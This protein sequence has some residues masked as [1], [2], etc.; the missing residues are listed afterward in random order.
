MNDQT[1][2]LLSWKGEQQGMYSS[3]EIKR[4]W[5]SE[6]ISGLYNVVT[7]SG[8][9][10]VQEFVSFEQEQSGKENLHQQQLAQAQ[11]EVEKQRFERDRL[12]AEKNQRLEIERKKAEQEKVEQAQLNEQ[13]SGKT[14]YLYLDGKKKGPYSK[15]NLQIMHQGGRIDES[16]QVWTQDLGEWVELKGFKEIVGSSNVLGPLPQPDQFAQSLSQQYPPQYGHAPSAYPPPSR[17]NQS[18]DG[19]A[20]SPILPQKPKTPEGLIAW[21]WTLMFIPSIIGALLIAT[22]NPAG[23][24]IGTLIAIGGALGC[25]IISIVL[26]CSPSMAGRVNG[27]IVL[28]L[29]IL[30]VIFQIA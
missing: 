28:A 21:V 3:T 2:A 6:E 29:I 8:N 20:Q 12:Q 13:M 18:G 30:G 9:L 25:F 17:M 7:E 16:T 14:Y 15:E 27:I 19:I 10:T 22:K 5:E 1:Y 23:M 26:T 11:A 4:M 24:I